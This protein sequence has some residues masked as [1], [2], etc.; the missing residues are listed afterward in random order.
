MTKGV[1]TIYLVRHGETPQHAENRYVGRTDA[2]LT[3]TGVAQ[4]DGLAGWAAEAGLAAIVCSPLT[5]ARLTAEPAARAAGLELVTDERWVELDFGDAEGLT[6]AEMRE[7]FPEARAAFEDDPFDHPLPGG[8]RPAD[9]LARSRTALVD[10]VDRHPSGRL[11]VVAHGTLIRILLCSL[12]GVEGS[13]RSRF[14]VF[15]NATGAVIRRRSAD[16]A[17]GLVALNPSLVPGG[18]VW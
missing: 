18:P 3:S 12:L 13:Y 15:G 9:A 14:P 11:L 10:L 6:A 2:P 8:E 16:A 4:A 17:V 1:H 7:R 5:R